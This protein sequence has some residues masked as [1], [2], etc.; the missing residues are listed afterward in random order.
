MDGWKN[1]SVDTCD[2]LDP[3][4]F[5]DSKEALPWSRGPPVAFPQEPNPPMEVI[6]GAFAPGLG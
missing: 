6:G 2:I 1:V 3:I 4:D 5:R